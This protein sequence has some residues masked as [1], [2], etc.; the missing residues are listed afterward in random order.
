MSLLRL[1]VDVGGTFTKAVAVQANPVR[2]VSQAVTPTTHSA[3]EGVAGGIVQVLRALLAH[4]EVPAESVSLV[5][6]STHGGERLL[7]GDTALVGILEWL[8]RPSKESASRTLGHSVLR[9]RFEHRA[10]FARRTTGS[11]DAAA[12]GRAARSRALGHARVSI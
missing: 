4:P 8:R 5:A 7:E 2:L 10:P 6:H 12:V 11:L 9:E 3:A 1:G